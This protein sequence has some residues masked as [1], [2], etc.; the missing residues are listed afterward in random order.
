[1]FT[2]WLLVYVIKQALDHPSSESGTVVV[3]LFDPGYSELT[4]NSTRLQYLIPG[5]VLL[6][7]QSGSNG[8]GD[9]W[10]QDRSVAQIGEVQ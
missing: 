2:T 3:V 5:S 10:D 6:V 1:M 7:A 8:P 9:C 4:S